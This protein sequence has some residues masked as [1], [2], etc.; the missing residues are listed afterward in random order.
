MPG[1]LSVVAELETY[2]DIL[3]GG[4]EGYVYSPVLNR[5]DNRWV[6]KFFRWPKQ[7]E[8]LISWITFVSVQFDVYIAPAL[9][10]E[11]SARK[12]S[13]LG[14]QV[15]WLEF[16]GQ[17]QVD[18]TGLPEPSIRI[19][20]SSETHVHL[21]WKTDFLPPS[22]IESINRKLTYHL[23]ADSSGWDIVQVLR[24]P[25]TYNW[26]RNLPVTMSSLPSTGAVGIAVTAEVFDF[27]KEPPPVI[28]IDDVSIIPDALDVIASYS[29]PNHVRQLITQKTPP[30]GLR[31]TQLMQL[32]YALA[33]LGMH[34]DEILSILL[35]ADD[36]IEKFKGRSDQLIRLA[37]VASIALNK[38]T[39]NFAAPLYSPVELLETD[40]KLFSH[41]GHFVPVMGN[42]IVAGAP[43]VGKTQFSIQAACHIIL[44]RDFIGYGTQ[45]GDGGKII[46]FSLE[47]P[48][49]GI[50][51]I[52]KNQWESFTDIEKAI[53]AEH[54]VFAIP[55]ESLSFDQIERVLREIQPAGVMFD[56]LSSLSLED[57]S[58]EKE[59]KALAEWDR[60]LRH[61]YECF[62]W[63]VHHN[64]KA[65]ADNKSALGLSDLYGS[66]IYGAKWDSVL[67]LA[68][69]KFYPAKTR[70][71]KEVPLGI[72]RVDF[73]F[74]L[75]EL[76]PPEQHGTQIGQLK[77]PKDISGQPTHSLETKS[78]SPPETSATE[79]KPDIFGYGNHS[80]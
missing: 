43:G 47:M 63:Y 15:V 20:T 27:L 58:S 22:I 69:D 41:W 30:K 1:S 52:V 18:L 64:R 40:F 59:S 11:K 62:T 35:I 21:Y 4:L 8:E 17:E 66:Y 60:H 24:P 49:P 31:S 55:T 70:Y 3:Y 68:K 79:P 56:S 9:F 36:R 6:Q 29:I 19:C 57:M 23:E 74:Q 7:R 32:G 16:D 26:K 25:N 78:A 80:H 73:M 51:W 38:Y 77:T 75:N 42:I 61:S 2:L 14:A 76:E 44:E 65:T 67:M 34:H 71:G 46:F 12:D 48:A 53:L 10:R 37:E 39:S 33:E 54:L 13:A 72:Q 5:L 28:S 45:L 50:Q